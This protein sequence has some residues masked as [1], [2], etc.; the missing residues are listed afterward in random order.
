MKHLTAF[1]CALLC[2][3]LCGGM[4][5][6]AED[7][8]YTYDE[9][10]RTL[11]EASGTQALLESGGVEEL[12][13]GEEL[14][15]SDPETLTSLSVGDVLNAAL[16]DAVSAF[17]QPMKIFLLLLGVVLLSALAETL[18]NGNGSVAT[19]YEVICVLCA[20]GTAA[21]PISQVFLQSAQTLQQA[22][23]FM[24]SFSAVFG[25]VLAVGGGLTAATGYQSAMV[26]ICEIA[27]E[28]A[29]RVLFPV[30]SMALAMSI[31]D[32]VNPAISLEGLIK[33]MHKAS[34]WILGFLMTIFLGM[35]SVQSMVAV[36]ADRLGTRTTKYVISNFVPFVGS[37]VS[38]AYSAVLGSMGIL[39]SGVGMLG[40][41]ALL[42]LLLPI[43]LQLGVYRF[44][45]AA[46]GAAAELFA[47]KRLTRL[48]RN[49]ESV[50]ATAFSVAVSFSVMFIVST[51]IMILIGGNLLT[52][53]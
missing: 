9:T 5:V 51:A 20:V 6:R 8:S 26:I 43:L 19:V 34:V 10:L 39:K 13:G 14:D 15:L 1:L 11:M 45:T 37:A 23:D 49:M 25:A 48:F 27:M 2:C 47:V 21:E 32:A 30:L 50:L 29:T 33:L 53:S 40:I 18:Q 24:L 42:T 44:L 7:D 38:D 52:S 41:L 35:L 36:S 12:L 16:Q 31:V 4:Q 22:A 28:L 3:L 17:V 46:A